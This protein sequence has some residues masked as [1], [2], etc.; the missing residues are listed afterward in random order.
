MI[1][2]TEWVRSIG[3]HTQLTLATLLRLL[4]VGYGQ[5]QDAAMEVPYTDVDYRVLT[6]A[7]RHV[8]EG[9]S[10]Y[11]RHTYRYSP[12]LSYLMLPNLLLSPSIGKLV[13]I[14]FDIYAGY[15][16]Y[17]ILRSDGMTGEPRARLAASLWLLNPLVMNVSTRGSAESVVVAVVLLAIHLY[18]QQV[19]LLAGLALG[20]AIHL[21]IYPVIFCL[22]LYCPL[23]LKSGPWSLLDIT[24]ARLR[25]LL[26][27]VFSLSLLTLIFYA[28]YDW[29]FLEHTYLYHITRKDIRHN[30]SVYFYLL[31]LTVE[32]DDAGLNLLT[33]LP[34]LVLLAAFTYKFRHIHQVNF[35]LFSLTLVFVTFNKV[36]TAQYFLWY[37][38]LLPLVLP[39][40]K[41]SPKELVVGCLLWGFAQSSWLL[42]A[43]LLEFK[44]H[45]TF[46]F[47][48][49][50]G[51]AFFCAN[52]GLLARMVRRYRELGTAQELQCDTDKLD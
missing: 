2:G 24:T 25:L 1:P 4:L 8:Y 32:Y 33:F 19:F 12:L 35:C 10:P 27:T 52:V 18:H 7:A 50:E 49:L 48:W 6:D 42:P 47:I 26:G 40:L 41:L 3:I 37:F 45:N 43:Y 11:E 34:Q 31:Y 15:L 22:A 5:H 23:S 17:C 28:L 21:K 16:V 44:G 14:V 39:G 36:V 13:F 30:F 38:S 29:E 9:G 46:M 51:L 20:T